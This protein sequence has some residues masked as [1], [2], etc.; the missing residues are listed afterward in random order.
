MGDPG[1]MTPQIMADMLSKTGQQVKNLGDEVLKAHE[2]MVKGARKLIGTLYELHNEGYSCSYEPEKGSTPEPQR[3]NLS[4][5]TYLQLK[6]AVG[7]A[8][9]VEAAELERTGIHEDEKPRVYHIFRTVALSH[10]LSEQEI[11]GII[12]GLN[13]AEHQDYQELSGL[14]IRI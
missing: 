14:D 12:S 3:I 4:S 11:P 13:G 8:L 6:N 1:F 10:G 5:D 2:T 9:H 7:I